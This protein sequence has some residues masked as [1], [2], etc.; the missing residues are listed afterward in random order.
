MAIR[1]DMERMEKVRRAHELWWK[2]QLDRPLVQMRLWGAY[3]AEKR[4]PAPVLSQANCADFSWSPEQVIDAIDGHLSQFEYLGD[5]YPLVNFDCY[6]PGV[7][8]AF[9]GAKL[10]NSSGRVWFFPE[11]EKEIQDIHVHYNPESPWVQRIKAIYRAGLDKWQGLVIMGMPDL[12]GVMDVAATFRGTENLMMDLYDE[13]E[14]VQRLCGEIQDA[15]YAAYR[16]LAGV[17]APQ[18]FNSNWAGL[19]SEG[20]SYVLQCDFAYMIGNPM[21][22]QFVL[23]T[24]KK[25]T[26]TLTHSIYHLDG[27]GQLNHLDDLLSL[28]GL[29]AVQWVPGDG[30][31]GAMHWLD[32]Y[33]RI[34]KAGKQCQILCN[35]GDFTRVMAEFHG[36]PYVNLSMPAGEKDAALKTLAIR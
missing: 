17:L 8:A 16:D 30:K 19:L 4:C 23:S 13:P 27:V 31:P 33:R 21:F 10:D 11:E 7:L 18:R 22:R 35:A 6:G 28:E 24:L 34:E 32:V 5:A 1:F 25:D 14:E 3:P 9:C 20:D 15:W 36:T 12:G 29:N 2:G 26:E